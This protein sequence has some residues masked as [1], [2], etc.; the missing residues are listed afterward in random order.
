MKIQIYKHKVQYYETDQMGVVHHSNYIRWFEEARLDFLTQIGLEYAEMEREDCLS[1]VVSISCNYKNS[2]K[3]GDTVYIYTKLTKF[4]G[5]KYTVT[6]K[7]VDAVSKEIRATGES[8]HCFVNKEG[9]L[10]SLKK[11]QRKYYDM[12]VSAV[13]NE[14]EEIA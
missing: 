4:N 9:K 12:L 13:D 5:I 3:F 7:I 1:P 6:Y 10:L 8:N 2:T 14:I 11:E